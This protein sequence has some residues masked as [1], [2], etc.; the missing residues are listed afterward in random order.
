LLLVDDDPDFGDMLLIALERRGFE[1]SPCA[2]PREALAGLRQHGDAWDAVVADQIMPHMT[3]IDLIHKIRLEC[4][5]LP[6]ILCTAYA[7]DQLDDERLRQ[8][9][10][11]ALLRKP[12]DIDDLTE[13]LQR[14]IAE[15]DRQRASQG[16]GGLRPDG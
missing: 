11:F 15:R 5:D 3:G 9:G 8:A 13:N 16:G 14:A 2:D 4:P 1:V 6:C 12:V 7:E 10:I